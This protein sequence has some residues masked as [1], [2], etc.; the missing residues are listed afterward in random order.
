MK[1][2]RRYCFCLEKEKK[3]R[4]RERERE[5]VREREMYS[6]AQKDTK[7]IGEICKM[8]LTITSEMLHGLFLNRRFKD[9]WR[10][11]EFWSFNWVECD[12]HI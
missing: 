5:R 11:R 12:L 4:E 3:E 6:R 10:N 7:A 2:L 1:L 8:L 9:S